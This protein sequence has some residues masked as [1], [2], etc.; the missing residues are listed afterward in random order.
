MNNLPNNHPRVNDP[1]LPGRRNFLITAGLSLAAASLFPT[2]TARGQS[3]R[4]TSST[5]GNLPTRKLPVRKLGA[6]EVSAVGLGCMSMVAGTYNPAPDR[7]QM[8]SLIRSAVERGVTFFD[9]AEVYGPFTSEEIVGEALAP[10]RKDVVIASKFGFAF[11]DGKRAGRDSRPGN[12]RR[13]VEGS[14]RRL[15]T[16]RI[17]LYYLH[18]TDPT[19]P[20]E[21]VAGAVKELIQAGKIAHFGLSE[22]SP[23]TLRRA[24]V[25]QTVTALQTEFSI[26][27]RGVESE[28][29]ATCED[30]GVGFVPW[31]PLGR[32]LLT[33][34][35]DETTPLRNDD[36]RR[37]VSQF[38]PEALKANMAL[39]ALIRRWA[40]KKGITPAQF[41]LGW[42][43]AQKPWIVPIPGTT[44]LH[45][46]EENLGAT[47][48]DFTPAE[49]KEIQAELST[50]AVQGSRTRESFLK[51]Q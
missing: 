37:S 29:L 22:V 26:L 20:I 25:V 15:R 1:A 10:L 42:L 40:E 43:L 11:Q 19:V 14:L 16:E 50:V 9:T 35:I 31:G 28:I 30:L 5:T 49:L 33:G 7:Q 2:W 36:R 18:R 51:D 12:I 47:A 13:T 46:L 32:A 38:Q 24:H 6:L 21:D 41:S 34:K 44:R 27:E 39:V 8:I 45:H 23:A 17:D 3:N 48:V 4:G